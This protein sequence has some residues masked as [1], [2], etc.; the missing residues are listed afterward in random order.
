MAHQNGRTFL[1]RASFV[2]SI[3]AAFATVA[4]IMVGSYQFVELEQRDRQTRAVDLF[5]KYNELQRD[6]ANDAAANAAR[7]EPLQQTSPAPSD[8]QGATAVR[9]QW[10]RNLALAI[11]ESIWM[12]RSDDAGW[13]NT[14]KWMLME[15]EVR[16]P[17]RLDCSTFD[18]EFVE[19]ARQSLKHPVCE[20]E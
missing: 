2:A 11:S 20:S 18:A 16:A 8:P 1:E 19:F 10:R 6:A 7:N 14:V 15:E 5:V 4:A 17:F 12:L 13:K 3:V 9:E